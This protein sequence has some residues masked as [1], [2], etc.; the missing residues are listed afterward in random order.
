MK[1]TVELYDDK[2]M[3]ASVPQRVTC[4]IVETH[5]PVKGIGVSPQY[6]LTHWNSS[7]LLPTNLT[8]KTMYLISKVSFRCPKFKH[9]DI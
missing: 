8:T 4:T 9:Q 7:Y 5:A 3:S 2:P 6:V 1:V